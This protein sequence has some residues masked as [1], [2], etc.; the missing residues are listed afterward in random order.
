MR[1]IKSRAWDCFNAEMIYCDS[2]AKARAAFYLD[3]ARRRDGGND[4][5]E[6][7]YIGLTDKKGVEIYEGDIVR[8]E[9]SPSGKMYNIAIRWERS[10]AGFDL[11]ADS[12]EQNCIVIGNIYE[13]VDLMGGWINERIS[14]RTDAGGHCLHL[15]LYLDYYASCSGVALKR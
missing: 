3:I 2:N 5:V 1:E 14:I 8:R 13:N 7:C 6:L 9:D 15:H 4:V 11:F 10:S 12:V